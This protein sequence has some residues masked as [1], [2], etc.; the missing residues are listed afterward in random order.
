MKTIIRTVLNKYYS[1]KQ[2]FFK[3]YKTVNSIRS[4]SD[5][6]S[7]LYIINKAIYDENTFKNFKNHPYYK[8]ILE[9]VSYDE[10]KEYL[11][12][13]IT[14]HNYLL[15]EINKFLKN[16]EIGNPQ[17]YFYSE[18]NKTISPT[19]LRYI[20]I[21]GDIKKIFKDQ[22]IKNIVEIGCGYGGQYLILDK[23]V[24]I[25]KYLLIDLHEVT[26]LIEKYLECHL[27]KS[28]Y[29]T[30]TIN[31]ISYDKSYDLVISN[32]A[33]SELPVETQLICIKKILL[34]SKNG[35]MLMNSG[36]ENSNFKKNHLSLEQIKNYIPEIKILPEE[37]DSYS[38]N[39]VIVWGN[40]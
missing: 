29:E 3:H 36:L 34:K 16:D 38:N 13:I 21:A 18:L 39:Y 6:G 9:H 23:I 12:C 25:D 24:K 20:K 40:I 2:R 22:V 31:R 26:K 4:E 17:K 28:T 30:K 5:N 14:N 27:L 37:P 15:K 11:R 33:F 32:Y 8:A 7:Y 19:T 35:Y 1:I 10:G